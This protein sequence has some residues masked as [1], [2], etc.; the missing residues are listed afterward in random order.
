MLPS[1]LLS[2]LK[3]IASLSVSS[4][5]LVACTL[6]KSSSDE[7]A[8]SATYFV[9]ASEISVTTQKLDPKISIPIAKTFSF[10][11][12]VKDNRMSQ[13][14]VNHKFE[15]ETEKDTLTKQTDA[16]GCLV[17]SEEI[18][19]NHLAPA[20]YLE[21]IRKIKAVGFQKGER[22][23]RFAINPWENQAES[24]LEKN[25]EDIVP[26][27]DLSISL[28][29][30]KDATSAA[31]S[32]PVWVDDLRLTVYEKQIS[33]KGVVLDFLIRTSPSMV[34]ISN[35]GERI[36]QPLTYGEFDTEISLIHVVSQ[37]QKEVRRMMEAPVKAKGI[38]AEGYL[39]IEAPITLDKICTRGQLEVGLKLIPKNAPKNLLPFEG[40]FV[41]GD[42]DQ[43]KG[44]S[45]ARLTNAFQEAKGAMTI[46]QYLTDKTLP[47]TPLASQDSSVGIDQSQPDYYQVGQVE[48]KTLVPTVVDYKSDIDNQ[49]HPINRTRHFKMQACMKVGLDQKGLRAQWFNVTSINGK[50]QTLKS[51]DDGCLNWDDTFAFKFFDQ[52]SWREASVRIT[53]ANLG[54]DQTLKVHIDPW[55]QGGGD[56]F[57]RDLR[58]A[59]DD[60]RKLYTAQG[61]SKIFMSRVSYSKVTIDHDIDSNMGMSVIKNVLM[62]LNPTIRRPSLTDP[63]AYSEEPLPIGPYVLR[64]AI[65][66]MSVEDLSQ[67]RGKIQQADEKIV[68]LS[69]NSTISEQMTLSTTDLDEIGNTNKLFVELFP[70]KENAMELKKQNP[71]LTIDDLTDKSVNVSH[72]LYWGTLTLIVNDASNS[73]EAYQK[74]KGNQY[75]DTLTSLMPS[76]IKQFQ[77][78]KAE[79]VTRLA[80]TGMKE[81]FAFDNTLV[82]YNLNNQAQS[83]NLRANL[84]FAHR[85]D[86]AQSKAR[87]ED[88]VAYSDARLKQWLA[89]GKMDDDLLRKM[90]DLF[91]NELLRS[92][93]NKKNVFS[94]QSASDINQVCVMAGEENLADAFNIQFR[95]FVKNPTLIPYQDPKDGHVVRMRSIQQV[96]GA[97]V[98]AFAFNK[99]ITNSE[100]TSLTRSLSASAKIDKVPGL[101]FLSGSAGINY[102]VSKS[103]SENNGYASQNAFSQVVSYKVETLQGQIRAEGVE[104]CA[105]IKLG[106]VYFVSELQKKTALTGW[107]DRLF[108]TSIT[109]MA[110]DN[111][112][113]DDLNRVLSKGLMICDGEY[114]KKVTNFT[115]NYYILNQSVGTPLA[116]DPNTHESRP[117]F[118]AIRGD[119]DMKRFNTYM[120]DS[121][122]TP[123]GGD[124][125]DLNAEFVSQKMK[126]IFS[127][128]PTYP[129][130]IVREN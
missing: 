117:F 10:K 79:K 46:D 120:Q 15:I 13:T 78:D 50:T 22:S 54:M 99:G 57:L 108:K 116:M 18:G 83:Q 4:L 49:Q 115:E 92:P 14:I 126:S 6:P 113:N 8:S 111:V 75:G 1:K 74:E 89:T 52:E 91:T 122:S 30:A 71:K 62:T 3:L 104:K 81:R 23:L 72:S 51:N 44:S 73:L 29:G 2:H 86:P 103:H 56:A 47:G 66:N 98:T 114:S 26:Y 68:Y 110:E 21:L 43:I 7:K 87:K 85:Y 27:Q 93:T 24:L 12:C 65:V 77:L 124:A 25:R 88:N 9:S 37:N 107:F 100:T 16:S 112:T 94:A 84:S 41:G 35:T 119:A 20:H 106:P 33:S 67:A 32:R 31:L 39:N 58:T 95:Y 63:S 82:T 69:A 53:N 28:M 34:L 96:D 36:L 109:Q 38:M 123:E 105:V 17:W 11:V 42:C 5:I 45:F 90:C 76:L 48:V 129:G 130:Q 101:A 118:M 59:T 80:K 55:A 127:Y 64:W 19:Y 128:A 121:Y 60:G 40:V 97:K 125:A 102:S 70:L 61:E